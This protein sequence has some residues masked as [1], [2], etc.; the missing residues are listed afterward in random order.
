MILLLLHGPDYTVFDIDYT[1]WVDDEGGILYITFT[2]PAVGPYTAFITFSCTDIPSE[3][4]T[5][6]GTGII[7]ALVVTPLVID[8]GD[9]YLAY[10]STP[11]TITVS[12]ITLTGDISYT[13]GGADPTVFNITETSWTPANG[14][15]LT[16]VF[17]PDDLRPFSATITF[18]TPDVSPDI[19]VTLI[20]TGVVVPIG[21]TDVQILNCPDEGIMRIGETLQ[22]EIEITPDNATNQA[23]I[24]SSSNI[25]TVHVNETGF[26][27]AL[28]EGT[29]TIT[30]TTVDGG[31]TAECYITVVHGV[32]SV[33]LDKHI[34]EMQV[35]DE[36]TLIATIYPEIAL[37]KD[38]IWSTDNAAVAE[39]DTEGN[40][41]AKSVG[42]AYITVTTVDGGLTDV[43]QVIV[44]EEPQL[45]T[46]I[47]IFP[48][49]LNLYRGDIYDALEYE[50]QPFGAEETVTWNS[51]STTVATVVDG[52]VTAVGA[53][54]ANITVRTINGFTAVCTV[55]VTVN[56]DSVRIDPP[57][58]NL[59]LKG[60]K[61]LKAIIYPSDAT[62]KTI[63]WSSLTPDIATVNTA[64]MVTAKTLNG[65]AIIRATN[66]ASGEYG[67][68]I[69]T[70][71]TGSPL[72]G[73]E[74]Q[75]IDDITIY[76]NPTTGIFVIKNYKT[77]MGN[78]ELFDVTG[79]TIET[80]LYIQPELNNVDISHL[81]T[82]IYF[83]RIKNDN[84]MI[85]KKVV[86]Q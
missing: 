48:T 84:E 28:E 61:V 12:G 5:L 81:P 50:I 68:C 82:G 25:N 27:I 33:I 34:L 23:V 37:V 2:P 39:V 11:Q 19:V 47:N 13:L 78:L 83:I 65:I 36:T 53:G 72:L 7:P 67:D 3:T 58:C 85:I 51:N 45:P 18:S 63:V 21:I 1:L 54:R 66:P 60:A 10:P 4:V 55:T 64:G 20:G 75:N 35:G 8:F 43:C 59:P 40:V 32:M 71:G 31:L 30:V 73:I 57:M 52:V 22:L 79:R 80:N 16:I 15:T 62:N 44:T 6:T 49:A 29:A 41:T 76:P 9:V 86:K 26:I 69:I 14:G 70:V 38:V 42:I 17:T 77:E 74:D 24:W 56:V 46:G